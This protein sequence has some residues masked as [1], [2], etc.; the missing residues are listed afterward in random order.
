MR[1]EDRKR[2]KETG[3]PDAFLDYMRYE[4]NRSELTVEAYGRDLRQFVDFV[5]GGKAETFAAEQTGRNDVRAWIGRLAEEGDSAR[6]IRRKTQAL[7]SYF[8]YLRRMGMAERNPADEVTLAKTE[9]P[10]PDFVRDEE[11]E[12]VLRNLGSGEDYQQKRDYLIMLLF[13]STGMR[14]AELTGL[15]DRDVDL[16]KLEIKATGK[17]MKQ[18]LIPIDRRLG[19]VIMDYMQAR[20]VS[21]KRS[22]EG[23][24]FPGRKGSLSERTVEKIVRQALAPTTGQKKSPHALRHSFATTLLNH[25]A[26]IN[27]VKELLGHSSIATTQIYTHVSFAEIKRN[28]RRA[29]PRG[30]KEKE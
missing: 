11:M 1:R 15:R 21:E 16:S 12:E 2:E 10:L 4:L 3:R 5:T 24:L 26:E 29:H 18:R 14:R 9:K 30:E 20:D 25:G 6:T 19:E 8:K 13:Y 27:S 23:Y 7:R 28:Y 22:D 17:R